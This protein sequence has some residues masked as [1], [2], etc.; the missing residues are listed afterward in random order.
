MSFDGHR[1]K[2][3]NALEAS[4]L[5]YKKK[6][7]QKQIA[8]ILK[9]SAPSVS[10]LLQFAREEDLVR[11]F[12]VPPREINLAR[13]L[14]DGLRSRGLE[15]VEVVVAGRTR[16]HVGQTAAVYF[17]KHGHSNTTVV[18]DGGKTLEEF[19][20]TLPSG[21]F[22]NI[23]I[24][25][26]C[27]DPPS[28]SVS[29]WELMTLLSTKFPTSECIKVPQ[30]RG[31]RLDDRI[32]FAAAAAKKAKF[33]FLG[34]GPWQRNYTAL[35]FVEHLGHDPDKLRDKYK[36]V[37]AVAG[38]CPM[39]ANGDYV[40]VEELEEA[41]PRSLTFE[42]IRS[43]ARDKDCRVVLVAHSVAKRDAV[44]IVLK[45]RLCNTIIVDEQL[46]DSLIASLSPR[47]RR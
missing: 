39:D 16:A 18:L 42:G 13:S 32:E 9:L 2:V 15:S 44:E 8:K 26:I 14:R 25:P 23:R 10:R 5:F 33:V 36:E 1:Q 17:Q 37:R 4:E 24:V 38:Y 35:E 21:V 41:M 11:I 3:E 31:G 29:A 6:L 34:V 30:H 46:A 19:V 43:L 7:T 28:Y 20:R 27:A 22:T 45:S 47:P 40:E 12:V